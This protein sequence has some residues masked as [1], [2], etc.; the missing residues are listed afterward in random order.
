MSFEKQL[1]LLAL[2]IPHYVNPYRDN[3]KS[4]MVHLGGHIDPTL[5]TKIECLDAAAGFVDGFKA[6]AKRYKAILSEP[7]SNRIKYNDTIDIVQSYLDRI[8][9][10]DRVKYFALIEKGWERSHT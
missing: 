6:Q 7:F 2:V 5:L 3:L 10:V 8:D 9:S 4:L 1:V